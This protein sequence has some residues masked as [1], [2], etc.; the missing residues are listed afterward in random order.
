MLDFIRKYWLFI[1][2]AAIAFLIVAIKVTVPPQPQPTPQEVTP[3][4]PTKTAIWQGIVP[5]Q[6]TIEQLAQI[7]K[8]KGYDLKS[9]SKNQITIESE[10]GGPPHEVTIQGQVVG[11][12]KQQVFGEEKLDTFITQYSQPEG[13]FWGPHQEAGFKTYV[14]PKN[15]FAVVAGPEE[16]LVAEVWYFTPNTLERFLITWGKELTS[17]PQNGY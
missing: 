1:I 7:A 4:Q 5:G 17:S 10:L 12:I 11:L 13:E 3:Q 15:G 9:V 2:L 8:L 16:G 14:F 6:T